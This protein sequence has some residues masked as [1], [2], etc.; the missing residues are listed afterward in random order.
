MPFSIDVN[1]TKFDKIPDLL[2]DGQKWAGN[3]AMMEMVNFIPRKEGDLRDSQTM[4][5]DGKTISYHVLYAQAQFR[6]FI[7]GHRIHNYTTPGTS[8]RWDLRLTGD[9][10][11]MNHVKK[12]FVKG[13]DLYGSGRTT[14]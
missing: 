11:K 10:E 4:S 13:A 14:E 9:Q 8:R 1:L 6:G 5:L 2:E 3:Q 12:A 7:N